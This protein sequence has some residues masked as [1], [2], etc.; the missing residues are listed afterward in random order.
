MVLITIASANDHGLVSDTVGLFTAML[1]FAVTVGV[2]TK[3][4]RIPYTITLVLAG[5]VIALLHAAPPG[6]ELTEDLV[7]VL[8]LPPLLFQAGLHTDLDHLQRK[9][10]PV[11]LLAIPGVV[12][13][14]VAVAMVI[15]PFLPEAVVQQHGAWMPALLFGAVLAPTDPISA[16]PQE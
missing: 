7:L 14:M 15:R 3:F 4:I 2:L 13:S 9:A 1:G 5:L 6:L 11:A 8:F 10:V 12:I 16:V